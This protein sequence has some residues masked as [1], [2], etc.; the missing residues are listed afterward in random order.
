MK[1]LY[2]A[3]EVELIGFVASEKIAAE[4][5]IKYDDLN[6]EISLSNGNGTSGGFEIDIPLM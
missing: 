2:I 3:P 4:G 5:T 1:E 6:S